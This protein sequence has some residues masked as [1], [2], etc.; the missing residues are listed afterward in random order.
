ML[1]ILYLLSSYSSTLLFAQIYHHFRCRW[2]FHFS[3]MCKRNTLKLKK[4]A[5]D[6]LR[7]FDTGIVRKSGKF[8]YRAKIHLS[9]K[10][11]NVSHI[12][13]HRYRNLVVLIWGSS[14]GRM[15]LFTPRDGDRVLFH[16]WGIDALDVVTSGMVGFLHLYLYFIDKFN[17]TLNR[18]WLSAINFSHY[19]QWRRQGGGRPQW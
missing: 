10:R 7:K 17:L 13:H 2:S 14:K 6:V 5:K 9:Y 4:F 15:R 1:W 8:Q 11:K 19:K 3:L 12:Q 16:Q 18:Y